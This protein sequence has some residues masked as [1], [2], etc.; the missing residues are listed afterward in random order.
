MNIQRT[1]SIEVV[2]EVEKYSTLRTDTQLCGQP[3]FYLMLSFVKHR[4]TCGDCGRKFRHPSHF[5]EHQRRHTGE[6][7]FSCLQCDA[8]YKTRNT[9]KRHLKV[10]HGKV[11]SPSGSMS[12]LTSEEFA[13][14]QVLYKHFIGS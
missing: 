1:H 6:S 7:P 5:K 4:F 11:L 13:K 10:Q 2:V 9:F 14:I 3:L 12:D 8:K